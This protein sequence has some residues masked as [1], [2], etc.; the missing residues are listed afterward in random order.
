MFCSTPFTAGLKSISLDTS[1]IMSQSTTSID[2]TERSYYD[3]DVDFDA[4]A[5]KDADFAAICEVSKGKRWIDFQDPK[6]VQYE[7]APPS[8]PYPKT[9]T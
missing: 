3:G 5:A 8:P 6:I 2:R 9:L 1:D 4:L 7:P